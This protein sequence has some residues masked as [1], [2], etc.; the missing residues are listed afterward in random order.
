MKNLN[1][2][3]TQK[4]LMEAFAGESQARNKYTFFAN[5][6]KK[7]GFVQ[8]SKIFEETANNEKEHAE[9]WYK[10]LNGGHI[11]STAANLLKAAQGEHGEWAEMY[12]RMAEEAKAE[13]FTEIAN[14]F[15][16]VAA[17]EKRHE[18]RFAAL[19]ENVK[20]ET[21]FSKGRV[22]GWIC[23]NCG[24]VVFAATAPRVCP[25]CKHAQAYY[26]L[27]RRDY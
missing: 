21:V 15:A 14:Q 18:E 27:E 25:V 26:K 3:K 7:D 16:G 20:K 13:G 9:I 10:W 22:D 23:M 19:L 4:N 11:S 5:Q 12:K 1:G 24:N 6:A 17:I 8:I 2:T